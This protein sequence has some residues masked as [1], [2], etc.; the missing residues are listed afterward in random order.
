[1]KTLTENDL[2]HVGESIITIKG[3]DHCLGSLMHFN[4][5]GS[6]C[7]AYGRVPVSKEDADIHNKALNQA[8]MEGLDKNC[9]VGMCGVFYFTDGKVTTFCGT[10]VNDGHIVSSGNKRKT[11][12]FNRKGMKFKGVLRKD[13]DDFTAKRIG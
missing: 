8:L 1:M 11:I 13:G 12:Y 9:E 6:F 5:K 2:E 10:Q 3:T 4:G 7:A